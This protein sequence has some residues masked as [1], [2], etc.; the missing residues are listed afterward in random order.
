[1]YLFV[2]VLYQCGRE[3]NTAGLCPLA[4]SGISGVN[5]SVFHSQN[6]AELGLGSQ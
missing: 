5:T 4:A 2:R 3:V 1:M 6:V